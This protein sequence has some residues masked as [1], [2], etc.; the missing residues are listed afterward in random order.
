MTCEAKPWS[1]SSTVG[2]GW[3][4]LQLLLSEE[5]DSSAR[6]LPLSRV[7]FAA[8]ESV[9][10]WHNSEGQFSTRIIIQA[11]NYAHSLQCTYVSAPQAYSLFSITTITLHIHIPTQPHSPES[12]GIIQLWLQNTLHPKQSSLGVVHNCQ[13]LWNF[14]WLFWNNFLLSFRADCLLF[15]QMVSASLKLNLP[16]IT[17][18]QTSFG[19]YLLSCPWADSAI[20][21]F[22]QSIPIQL[23]EV[24]QL[25]LL[26]TV[27]PK[28]NPAE[29]LAQVRRGF[30]SF[31][32]QH[33]L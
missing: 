1:C 14:L 26:P 29:L 25:H 10:L 19:F 11:L 33:G 20:N 7:A 32:L 6:G 12:G 23:W 17:I 31:P 18:L 15:W 30:L 3:C 22:I 8:A 9:A 13:D 21:C 27:C 2:A 24:A 28:Q 16:F 4:E 5:A